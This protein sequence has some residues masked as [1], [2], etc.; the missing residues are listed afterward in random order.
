[1]LTGLIPKLLRTNPTI[2][3]NNRI[4]YLIIY[5]ILI[6]NN[7]NKFE[8][9]LKRKTKYKTMVLNTKKPRDRV[10]TSALSKKK[11]KQTYKGK[12]KDNYKKK[13]TNEKKVECCICFNSVN[14][15]SDNSITCGKTT[16]FMCGECK[17]RCNETGNT[18]CPMCRSHPIKNPIARDIVLLVYSKGD[19]FKKDKGYFKWEKMSPKK[20][21]EFSRAGT[22]YSE[23]FHVDTNRLVRERSTGTGRSA[24]P[25]D[26]LYVSPW[27][28]HDDVSETQSTIVREHMDWI[29]NRRVEEEYNGDFNIPDEI[30]SSEILFIID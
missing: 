21:R 14:N 26:D 9:W 3:E 1:M 12:K 7:I 28:V 20:R 15:T 16:H 2:K 25:N 19:K 8:S 18:N 27:S 4:I 13:D 6:E 5:I 30:D 29:D 17:Y 24:F 10:K 23:P 22:I 11:E